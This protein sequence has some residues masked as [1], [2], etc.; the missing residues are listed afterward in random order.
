MQNRPCW[1]R[2]CHSAAQGIRISIDSSTD[3]CDNF[4]EFACGGIY[5]QEN[6]F[7]VDLKSFYEELKIIIENEI[8]SEDSRVF[9]LVKNFYSSCMNQTKTEADNEVLRK[10]GGLP[11]VEGLQWNETDFDWIESIRKLRD[12]GLT[13]DQLFVVTIVPNLTN[14]SIRSLTVTCLRNFF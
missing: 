8:G 1:T 5:P 6:P 11:L 10:I 14:S 9:Q 7:A 3:A 4:Y 12:I 13:T 2:E